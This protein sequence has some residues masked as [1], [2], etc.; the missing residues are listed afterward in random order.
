MCVCVYGVLYN[1]IIDYNIPFKK[2]VHILYV[3]TGIHP[4]TPTIMSTHHTRDENLKREVYVQERL[5]GGKLLT[6]RRK[7]NN[8][9]E[10]NNRY[11]RR[12]FLR[13]GH[14]GGIDNGGSYD[15]LT[16]DQEQSMSH[17]IREFCTTA[18]KRLAQYEAMGNL[19]H[20]VTTIPDDDVPEACVR[21]EGYQAF[22]RIVHEM[23]KHEAT[24]TLVMTII[25]TQIVDTLSQA[26]C[27]DDGTSM[28]SQDVDEMQTMLM[29]KAE[30]FSDHARE[31]AKSV[32]SLQGDYTAVKS[33]HGECL[34]EINRR[35][36][37]MYELMDQEF[38][39]DAD[40]RVSF[41]LVDTYYTVGPLQLLTR[42]TMPL[43]EAKA[44]Q[45]I[46]KMARPPPKYQL[47]LVAVEVTSFL[48]GAFSK[49][50]EY[51][52]EFVRQEKRRSALM[53][54]QRLSQNIRDLGF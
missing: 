7:A 6:L 3:S 16:P 38:G 4:S 23:Q 15:A 18:R 54:A 35:F 34:D 5:A 25:L 17:N 41:R 39:A 52:E 49:A 32:Y 2:R 33:W 47:I 12:H 44:F 53:S 46:K 37:D 42:T 1:I 29:N 21:E 26:L 19:L 9:I 20:L 14:G 28:S 10:H 48:L 27:S 24:F 50:Q 8:I 31:Y 11:M 51:A 40:R 43:K 36:E 30:L 45:Q 22:V 13:A